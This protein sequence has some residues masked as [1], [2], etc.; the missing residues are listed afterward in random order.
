M[1]TKRGLRC[2]RIIHGKGLGSVNKEPVLKSKVQQLAGA[3]GRSDRLLPGA[4]RRWRQRRA[5]GAAQGAGL[6]RTASRGR[7]P[8]RS[9]QAGHCLPSFKPRP[10]RFRRCECGSPARP[11]CTKIL[12]SPILPVRAALMIASTA[13]SAHIVAPPL[14]PSPS[15]GNRPHIRRR[16]TAR[17]GPF[18]RPKPFTSVTVRPVTPTSA[19]RF[20]HLV[21]LE[22]F[23]NRSNLFHG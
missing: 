13:W 8:D 17:Y 16:D 5:D 14:R 12:P 6:N 19:K 7:P 23:D 10:V 1:P 11:A 22:R 15:A 9:M 4:R 18:W 21:Q 3:K 20:A 2:V